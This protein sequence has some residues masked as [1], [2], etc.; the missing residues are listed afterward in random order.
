MLGVTVYKVQLTSTFR[1]N[2]IGSL[3]LKGEPSQKDNN[4]SEGGGG[5]EGELSTFVTVPITLSSHISLFV[6]AICS[7]TIGT[8]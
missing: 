7:F 3:K 4:R 1:Q 8:F 6:S 2:H 5:G